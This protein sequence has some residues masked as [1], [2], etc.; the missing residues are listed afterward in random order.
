[1]KE[2]VEFN[3]RIL[4][5]APRIVPQGAD[6]L[7]VSRDGNGDKE[8]ENLPAGLKA[9]LDQ[10]C[11]R[12]NAA[13]PNDFN[14]VLCLG[15]YNPSIILEFLDGAMAR[16]NCAESFSPEQSIFPQL[17]SVDW[18]KHRTFGM[19]GSQFFDGIRSLSNEIEPALP[20]TAEIQRDYPHEL[21]AFAKTK[22]DGTAKVRLLKWREDEGVTEESFGGQNQL[23]RALIDIMTVQYDIIAVMVDG[24]LLPPKKVD[25]LKRQ[26]LDEL[27]EQMPI[28]YARAMRVF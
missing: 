6:C 18:N 19:S 24:K 10:L 23:R 21:E 13:I 15:D 2:I 14:Y 16:A 27:R 9:D 5:E 20:G 4:I 28:S 11:T 17:E 12:L 22:R 25:K 1:M 8:I 26:T 7:F 3:K